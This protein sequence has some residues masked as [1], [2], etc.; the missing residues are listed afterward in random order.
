MIPD[1]ELAEEIGE[2]LAESLLILIKY[3][4]D[5]YY[6]IINRCKKN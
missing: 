1:L 6:R 2:S 4:K 5:I 3:T